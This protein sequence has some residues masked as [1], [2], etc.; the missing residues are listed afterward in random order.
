MVVNSHTN[1]SYNV[2]QKLTQFK[3]KYK[4]T[5]IIIINI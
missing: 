2:T 4:F 5:I 3:K 1:R